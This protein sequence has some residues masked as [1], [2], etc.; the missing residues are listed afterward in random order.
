MLVLSL[1]TL[2]SSGAI[3]THLC[4]QP[5]VCSPF[6][7]HLVQVRALLP[8]AISSF[9][10]R[11]SHVELLDLSHLLI[12]ILPLVLYCGHDYVVMCLYPFAFL[13]IKCLLILSYS[14]WPVQPFLV[15][16]HWLFTDC[17]G[18]DISADRLLRQIA[19]FG[20]DLRIWE[21]SKGLK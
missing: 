15:H 11:A 17:Q 8:D 3:S 21:N 5:S 16:A 2:K 6:K 1:Q 12:S 10:Y 13:S 7:R 14:A 4:L 18:Q 19:K 20:R 9:P